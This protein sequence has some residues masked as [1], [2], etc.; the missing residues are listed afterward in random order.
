MSGRNVAKAYHN[1]KPLYPPN[2][3]KEITF[4]FIALVLLLFLFFQS[5]SPFQFIHSDNKLTSSSTTS[6]ATKLTAITWN[7]AAINN[8][9]FEYYIST[10]MLQYNDLM[11][12]ISHIIQT[13]SDDIDIPINQIF[14]NNMFIELLEKINTFPEISKTSSLLPDLWQSDY[15]ERKCISGFIKDNLIGMIKRI[16]YYI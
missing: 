11:N 14:S 3:T 7:I 5:R 4:L 12:N 10:D 1:S 16:F 9:P 13:P 2:R 8:N 6:K 15:S